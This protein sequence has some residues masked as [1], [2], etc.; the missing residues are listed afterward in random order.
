M[1]VVPPAPASFV[2]FQH[3]FSTCPSLSFLCTS[4]NHL[5]SSL[6]DN[7]FCKGRHF[8]CDSLW[9]YLFISYISERLMLVPFFSLM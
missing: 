7:A 5:V 2:S 6:I 8:S 3:V 9:S 4:H 1:F